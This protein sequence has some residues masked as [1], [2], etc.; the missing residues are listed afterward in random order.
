MTKPRGLG[1]WN[2]PAA[3][4]LAGWLVVVVIGRALVGGIMM[5]A[6]FGVAAALRGWL[7]QERA[8]GLL[9]RSRRVDV[10]LYVGVAIVV[11]V[12]FAA[13]DLRPRA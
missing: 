3:L 8:G 6:A 7:P 2:P 4:L 10:A 11:L 13:V 1:A 12:G 9:V 5:A